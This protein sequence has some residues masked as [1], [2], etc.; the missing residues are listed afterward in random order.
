MKK[1]IQFRFTWIDLEV[2]KFNNVYVNDAAWVAG[3][4]F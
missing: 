1:W 3:E 2:L 4:L